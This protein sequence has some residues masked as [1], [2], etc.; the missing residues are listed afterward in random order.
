M[1]GVLDPEHLYRLNNLDLVVA[2][3]QPVRWALNLLHHAQLPERVYGPSL[4]HWTLDRA[5]KEGMAIY[6]YGSNERVLHRMSESVRQKFPALHIAGMQASRFGPV[7]PETADDIARQIRASGA[8]LVFAGL[9]CPRQEVWAYE[10]RKRINLPIVAVGAAF[11]IAA[12][13]L[14]QAPR[15]MQDRGL[16]WLFRLCSEPRRLWRRY[17]LLSPAYLLLVLCQCLGM[18]FS[19][20]GRRP[21]R[22]ILHG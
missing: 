6:L 18:K 20:Q 14:P 19:C 10:F 2:D 9:G 21:G 17:L 12:G 8:D 16:E 22:E 5:A 11:P 13:V 3:G 15:W 4:M 1:T 7:S